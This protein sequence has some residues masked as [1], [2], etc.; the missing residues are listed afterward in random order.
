MRGMEKLISAGRV[1]VPFLA[2]SVFG[3]QNVFHSLEA[4]L[5]KNV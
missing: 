3:Y 1:Q 5:L 2:W 4:P